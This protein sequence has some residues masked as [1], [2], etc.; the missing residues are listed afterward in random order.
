M[1]QITHERISFMYIDFIIFLL[2]LTGVVSGLLALIRVMRIEKKLS[3]IEKAL[4]LP[5]KSPP[6]RQAESSNTRTE[7]HTQEPLFDMFKSITDA[8]AVQE[9]S[10]SSLPHPVMQPSSSSVKESSLEMQIGSKWLNWIGIILII[11]GIAFFLK[12]VIDNQ[13]IGPRGRIL[14]GSASGIA[15]LGLGEWMRRREYPILF[16]T[17][18]GGGIGIFY[19][20]IYFAFQIY[21]LIGAGAAFPLACAVTFLAIAWAVVHDSRSLCMIGQIGG[22]ISPFLFSAGSNNPTGLF[23]YIL[24]LDG[25]AIGSAIF[26]RWSEVSAVAFM[27]SMAVYF[28]WLSGAYEVSQLGVALL[29]LTLFYLI[30]LLTPIIPALYQRVAA[31]FQEFQLIALN[32][33]VTLLLYHRLL[34]EQHRTALGYVVLGMALSTYGLYFVYHSR[35]RDEKNHADLLL[36]ASSLLAAVAIPLHFEFYALPIAWAIEGVLL[37][38]MARREKAVLFGVLSAFIFSLSVLNLLDHLPLHEEIFLPV[39][40]R[41]F[42]S[43][44]LVIAGCIL[45][46]LIQKRIRYP[47]VYWSFLPWLPL[48]GGVFLTLMLLSMETFLFWWVRQGIYGLVQAR[49]SGWSSL[50]TLW[51]L[52]VVIF[53][54]GLRRKATVVVLGVNASVFIMALFILSAGWVYVWLAPVIPLFHFHFLSRTFFVLAAGYGSRRLH[55]ISVS[56]LDHLQKSCLAHSLEMLAHLLFLITITYEINVW[57][58]SLERVSY[59]HKYGL[60][61]TVWS[62]YALALIYSGLRSRVFLRRV[63]GC[64]LFGVTIGKVFLV[65]MSVVEPFY[66]ILSFIACGIILVLAGYVYQYYAKVILQKDT[67]EG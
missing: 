49:I 52:F 57:L 63:A 34:V 50:I 16:Q 30:F 58:D 42:G 56:G 55:E 37:A 18:T 28:A 12:Y 48:A 41:D 19:I 40:N 25:V 51:S 24:I 7:S 13:W 67:G 59:L 31:S 6:D 11:L 44:S 46:Y 1:D 9:G 14:I 2:S 35:C 32:I 10:A 60:V 43:W 66:R 15:A 61:S 5:V 62:V 33:V 22:F 4:R 23:I 27:G 17:L 29:F 65:D 26:K 45:A 8:A 53:V 54:E 38:W 36:I 20:C 47:S 3:E 64:I 21:G 39:L